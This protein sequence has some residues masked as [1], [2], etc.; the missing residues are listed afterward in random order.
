[1]TL[2][3]SISGIRGTI[4]GKPGEGLT[5][6]DLTKFASAYGT[7]L[8][9]KT[10]KKKLKV[11]IGRDAR[12]SGDMVCGIVCNTLN[13]I[14]VDTIELGMATTP[15]VEMAVVSEN[16]DGGI[17]ITASHNPAHWNA[18]KLL[19]DRGE[20][21]SAEEGEDVL[22]IAGEENFSFVSVDEL[23]IRMVK[24]DYHFNHIEKILTLDLVQK[25]LIRKA[26]FRVVVDGV[27]S[28][29]GFSV[30]E[31]LRE[32]GV[33]DIIELNC[34]PTGLFAHDPE[35]LPKN[36]KELSEA[37][38]QHGADLGIVVDPDVDRLAFI[39]ENGEMFG[40]EYTLVAV[41]DYVLSRYP[42]NTVSNLSSTEALSR[43]TEKYGGKRYLAA[44]GEVNVVQKM[45][46]VNAVIGGEGNGGVI[47]PALHYGRDA[48]AGIALF[49]SHL[50]EKEKKISELRK[51]Y[52]DYFMA[53][54]KVPYT[55]QTDTGKVFS[56]VRDYFKDYPQNTLDGLFIKLEGGWIHFRRSNTEPVFRIYI[57][58]NDRAKTDSLSQRVVK[59]VSQLAS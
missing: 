7:W 8:L 20:F 38:V 24:N 6:V 19:N 11:V 50:A 39:C 26:G 23:G 59:M 16:A 34:E 17:I 51:T 44:V 40:E 4:G 30:P 43:V 12:I 3:S 47:Y 54:H 37:V 42:G 15:T 9:K 48:L 1:M 29:G 5:P 25:D 10:G 52:P 31:L 27:N 18:L 55:D 14:G 22:K 56:G 13:A 57:E 36:L 32:L 21:L 35:P 46:E 49:L 45:K 58:T 53:K 2:I 41:A 28:V 33:H